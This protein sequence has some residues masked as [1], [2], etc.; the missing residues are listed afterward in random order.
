M[1]KLVLGFLLPIALT[2]WMVTAALGQSGNAAKGK[3]F[4]MD[5]SCYA[6][7]GFSG[8]NG[9]GAKL[10]PMKIS[11]V[12]FTAYVRSPR[13][14]QMPTYSSKVITDAQL[15]DIHAYIQTLKDAPKLED[16]ELLRQIQADAA[17]AK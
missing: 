10:V 8:Q 7:H 4:F 6:C 17:K 16:I 12:A 1:K 9:T 5:Y 13:T 14:K 15:A 3:Q 11:A 2:T